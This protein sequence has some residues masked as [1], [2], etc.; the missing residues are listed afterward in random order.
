MNSRRQRRYW[1]YLILLT[2]AVV[3]VVLLAAL[4]ARERSAALVRLADH[5]AN[6][7]SQQAAIVMRQLS[8]MR[9]PPLDALVIAARCL[10]PAIANPARET[11]VE[12][13]QSCEQSIDSERRPRDVAHRLGELAGA[14]ARQ[15]NLFPAA[16]QAWIAKTT[17]E[18]VRLANRLP[19]DAAPGLAA[20]CDAILSAV[21]LVELT[22]APFAPRGERPVTG[23][24]KVNAPAASMNV[25]A[26]TAAPQN[27]LRGDSQQNQAEDL[28]ENSIRPTR[29]LISQLSPELAG[30]STPPPRDAVSL[31]SLPPGTVAERPPAGATLPMPASPVAV[32]FD[33]FETRRLLEMWL[34]IDEANRPALEQELSRRGFNRLTKQWI[35]RYTSNRAQD[36]LQLIDDILRER[37]VDAR[38]WL[39]L[40]ADDA[41]G[42]V[43]LGAITVMAT[44]NDPMLLEKA[45]AVALRDR[46]PRIADLAGRLRERLSL[47][48]SRRDDSRKR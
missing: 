27:E 38:P 29:P 21:E 32:R 46:D 28:V 4:A 47:T 26:P 36:R 6:N 2:A 33:G 1:K 14:L 16:D 23:D 37:N 8:A 44:S 19:P 39:I 18:L 5:V 43:R 9:H 12:L 34:A 24:P 7:E 20:D 45:L 31:K 40:L 42:D 15:Q 48:T 30:S 11:L 3:P 41:S 35:D 10:D 13:L 25:R 22:E 17:H